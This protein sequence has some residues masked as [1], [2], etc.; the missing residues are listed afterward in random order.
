MRIGLR[1][2]DPL[3]QGGKPG[4]LAIKSAIVENNEDPK[5]HK[6]VDDHLELQVENISDADIKDQ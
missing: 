2:N 5:I 1:G 3:A 4:G 6:A